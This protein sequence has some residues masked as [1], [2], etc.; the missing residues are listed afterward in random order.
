MK[1]K[2]TKSELRKL[3]L[4]KRKVL[5]DEAHEELS[6]AI[7]NQCLQLPIWTFQYFHLFLPIKY[8]A[9]IDSTILLTILQGRDKEIVLPK[10]KGKSDLD[11][12]LLT[13]STQ[14][15]NNQWQI[16]E[17]KEG[18][19]FDPKKLDVVFVPLLVCD[20]KGHRVGYGKG[21]YDQF[22]K[23]CKP[24]VLKIGLSFFEPIQTIED[25]FEGDILLDYCVFPDYITTF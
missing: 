1:I 22:L 24:D 4:T 6:F 14:I 11:H 15:E 9:E 19:F 13:D 3:Y 16:P 10:L 8:K 7:A 2:Y 5:S 18:I 20:L 12:I 25:V 23:Q 21:F 17:P